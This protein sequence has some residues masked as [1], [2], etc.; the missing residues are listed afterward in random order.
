MN[1][2]QWK[3]LKTAA[4]ISVCKDKGRIKSKLFFLKS[5]INWATLIMSL[6]LALGPN[7]K[8]AQIWKID[9]HHQHLMSAVSFFSLQ[10]KKKKERK[11]ERGRRRWFRF[12]C[13]LAFICIFKL[14]KLWTVAKQWQRFFVIISL[15]GVWK[16]LYRQV[17]PKEEAIPKCSNRDLHRQIYSHWY[18]ARSS[19]PDPDSYSSDNFICTRHWL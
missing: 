7:S 11:K 5:W 14:V 18:R 15:L 2:S 13:N 4:F 10:R 1:I 12:N 16:W 6:S 3:E 9:F 17:G 8:L 19:S